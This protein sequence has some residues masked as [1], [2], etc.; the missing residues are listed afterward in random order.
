MRWF[1]N[2]R[3]APKLALSF[4]L[5][6]SLSAGLGLFALRGTARVNAAAADLGQHWLPTVRHSLALS[7]AVADFRSAETMHV[8]ASGRTDK[9]GYEAE[10]DAHASTVEDA[11]KK[12]RASITGKDDSVAFAEYEGAWAAYREA[13]EKL[14]PLSRELKTAEAY[15]VLQG[16]SQEQ[17]DKISAALGRIVDAAEEGARGQVAAGAATYTL[18]QRSVLAAVAGCV[19]LGVLVGLTIVRQVARPVRD[20]AERMQRLAEGDV[21][22]TVVDGGR[23]EVGDLARSFG[24]IVAAQ[25][26][27]ADAARR[28]A[29]GDVSVPVVPR[30]ERDALARS[31]GEMQSAL[32]ALVGEA[33]ALAAAAGRGE[34]SARGN[35][36]RFRGAYRELV[37]EM[38]GLL[39]E[40]SA[41][42]AELTGAL[43]RVADRDLTARMT[44]SYRGSFAELADSF[45]TAIGTLD[46]ALTHVAVS[47]AGVASTGGEIA[48]G[49][50]ALAQ[51]AAQQA[52]A[53][54]EVSAAL[55]ELAAMA[56]QNA[57]HARDARGM[58]DN[59]R[60]GA[61][62]GVASMG[63]LS[64]AV[65][66]IKHSADRTA[67]VVKTIDEIAFQTNLLALNA[68]VE[69]A[70][71]GDAGRGFAVVA[72]EVRALA[73]RSAA[74]ARETGALIAESVRAAGEGVSLNAEVLGRL[75]AINA[76]V[77]R[78]GAVMAEIA[79][80]SEQQDQG[81]GQIN[82]G[83]DS[84]NAVTQQV[85][86]SA[87]QSSSA[88]VELS[89]QADAMAELVSTFA[90]S[91]ADGAVDTPPAAPVAATPAAAPRAAQPRPAARPAT[92]PAAP[93]AGTHR[94]VGASRLPA[95]AWKP[96]ADRGVRFEDADDV[97][98]EF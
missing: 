24:A 47:S 89:S 10:M 26:D 36:E 84:M 96:N 52:G 60:T 48:S 62:G 91:D 51:G 2:I 82:A 68:A 92:P 97:L 21:D 16:D 27:V 23:D 63:R 65:E 35:A 49:S 1:R 80:A 43:G 73:Q 6:L 58:A 40:L 69:A 19:L 28:M 81:V 56:K 20:I 34:L 54:E 22:Q 71:A 12:V 32:Q 85:A 93:H 18:T 98:G 39:G 50:T 75:R 14:L 17:F 44:G 90:L 67:S 38:N 3:L 88:S 13:H 45:N 78:V 74:A 15:G 53:L 25:R 37:E 5:L 95:D 11:A 42:T 31:F 72:E 33:G 64:E 77:D 46:D 9:D 94:P 8:I 66:R 29:E 86:T 79:A 87:Q 41:P 59:A 30:S 61:A 4:A 83:L 7:R 57:D 70:R 55:Q 76:D